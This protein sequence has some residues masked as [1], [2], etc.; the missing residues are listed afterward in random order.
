LSVAVSIIA[1]F[2][3]AADAPRISIA[4][5]AFDVPRKI[6]HAELTIPA[7]AGILTLYFPKWIPGEHAPSGPVI[8]LAGL[9]FMG[10]ARTDGTGSWIW[11]HSSYYR[12]PPPIE[13][14]IREKIK[15]GWSKSKLSREFL[16]NRRTIIR[17]CKAIG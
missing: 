10:P 7:V 3:P 17:I 2:L 12:V 14:A 15:R 13:E 11:R 1:L 4:L 6:F 8:N 5:D 9:K 16:L